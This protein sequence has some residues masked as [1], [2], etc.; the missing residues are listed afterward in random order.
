MHLRRLRLVSFRAH[1]E[2]T[3]AFAPKVNLLTGANGAGKTNVLEAVHYLCLSK[4]FLTGTDA[5]ALRRDR[6]FFEVEGAFE[7]ER[8]PSLQ[9]RLVYVPDEGKKLF[10]NRAP[11]DR[12]SDVVGQLPVVVIA[13]DDHDLTAGGPEVRRRFLDN[14]L[15]QSK[16]VYL[17]DLLKY[18][19]ALRQRNALLLHL[20]RNRGASDAG[21]DA[22]TE[23]VVTLGARIVVRRA[24]FLERFATFLAEAYAQ[25]G[26]VGEEP[27]FAYQTFAPLPEG[28]A[29]GL[30]R[31]G[32]ADLFRERLARRAR[33][34]RDRGRTMLGPHRDEIVFKLNG[35]EVRPYASQG[36]HRTF[37]LA[38]KLAK[39]FFLKDRLDETPLLLLDDVFGT[40]DMRR[41]RVVLA[42]L[43]SDA[44]GQS[45]LTAAR[46]DAFADL[47]DF[48]GA[49]HRHL[50]VEGGQVL[51]LGVDNAAAPPSSDARPA[52]NDGGNGR[53]ETAPASS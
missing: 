21:L 15:S 37:G 10:I 43:R 25:L 29:D 39:F 7:S 2:S 28:P 44:V 34:E 4:S 12:L 48:D 47:I 51:T 19:R 31:D 38:L 16:P 52:N 18:R 27:T 9:V 46:A 45:L 6:P 53:V 50:R 22:W 49:T 36:Q 42:L 35:F 3:L 24:R 23:E 26:E 1:A 8:R 17:D 14:T 32:V 11:L 40:L 41:A 5:Y 33:Q 30:D 13:P 20:K